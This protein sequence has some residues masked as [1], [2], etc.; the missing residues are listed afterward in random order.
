MTDMETTLAQLAGLKALG[1][2]LAVDDFGTGYSSL[3]YL[4]RFP[5]DV[6]KVDKAFVDELTEGEDA[7]LTRTIVDL[8]HRLGLSV[9]AEGI[10]TREQQRRL[11]E[12]G[13]TRGQG[14]LYARP[15]PASA[16]QALLDG[17]A[18]VA[19]A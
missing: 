19:T 4:R 12:L 8:G 13:C 10:E 18:A 7:P 11:V 16:V 1:V 3:Q 14:F 6:L 17:A 2:L 5:I 9:V 15:A